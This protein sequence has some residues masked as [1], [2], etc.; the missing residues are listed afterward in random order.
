MVWEVKR[1]VNFG[2]KGGESWETEGG[3]WRAG[4]VLYFDLSAVYMGGLISAI[5]ATK[6]RIKYYGFSLNML[7]KFC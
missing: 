5:L 6:N 1:V 7:N 4:D 3:F 2:K